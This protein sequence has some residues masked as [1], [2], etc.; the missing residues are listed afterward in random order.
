MN[1]GTMFGSL[2]QV[3]GP[4]FFDETGSFCWEEVREEYYQIFALM[5]V[6]GYVDD[7]NFVDIQAWAKHALASRL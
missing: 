2:G 5:V 3:Q 4:E 7:P 6:P 1:D